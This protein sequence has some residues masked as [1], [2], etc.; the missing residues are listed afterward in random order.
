[1]SNFETGDGRTHVK[2]SLMRESLVNKDVI[3]GTDSDHERAIMP[4][5]VL[6]SIG[7]Q[8]IFDRGAEATPAA[9]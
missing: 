2:S 1:M 4:D 6:V 3:A 5:V 8:S 9:R 7:G